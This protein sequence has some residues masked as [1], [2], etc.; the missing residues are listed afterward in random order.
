MELHQSKSKLPSMFT[1]TDKSWR[2]NYGPQGDQPQTSKAELT[3]D[4]KA[5]I[6]LWLGST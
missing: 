6:Q 4:G 1:E 5:G 2:V 3:K